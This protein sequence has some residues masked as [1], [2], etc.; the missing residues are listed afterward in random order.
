MVH[1]SRHGLDACPMCIDVQK[2]NERQ[3]V[4]Q[5][6]LR[7]KADAEIRAGD[8]V[9]TWFKRKTQQ[10]EVIEVAGRWCRIRFDGEENWYGHWARIEF[11]KKL[12]PQ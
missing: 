1:C 7:E 11:V 6:R 4:I 3:V 12:I 10:G 8:R 9:E 2:A 5:S